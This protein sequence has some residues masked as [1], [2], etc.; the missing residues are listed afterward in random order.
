MDVGIFSE[1]VGCDSGL[2][3][4]QQRMGLGCLK[5]IDGRVSKANSAKNKSLHR[6]DLFF[7]YIVVFIINCN[8]LGP[9]RQVWL[10]HVCA[11]ARSRR[12]VGDLAGHVGKAD[13]T[14]WGP[15]S[16]L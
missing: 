14:E 3:I 11:L 5:Q 7:G 13:L 6:Q 16:P 4:R 12:A 8:M 9:E 10:C 2:E 15:N 1:H